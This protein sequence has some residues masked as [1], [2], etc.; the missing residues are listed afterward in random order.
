MKTNRLTIV[1]YIIS[2]LFVV[3]LHAQVS[4]HA[5]PWKERSIHN[6]A[7]PGSRHNPSLPLTVPITLP[8]TIP[9]GLDGMY[10]NQS[11]NRGLHNI[12]IDPD[13]PQNLH[14]AVTF[15]LDIT[16]ADT[17]SGK[18]FLPQ[19]RVYYL[20][21]SDDGKTWSQPKPIAEVHTTSPEMILMKRGTDYVPMIAAVRNNADTSNP[22][23][24]AL[25]IEQGKP[26]DGNFSE[27][28]TDRKTF[29]DSLKNINFPSIALSGDGTKIF[30]TAGIDVNDHVTPQYVQFG[31][32]TLTEDR[33]GATWGGWKPGPNAG[34]K[35]NEDP[36]GF[37]FPW[38]TSVRVSPSGKIGVLWFNRDYGTPDLSTYLSESSDGGATWLAVPKTVVSP[39]STPNVEATTGKTYML[40]PFN[41]D[42]WYA[43]ETAEAAVSGFY[44]NRDSIKGFYIPQSGSLLFWKEGMTKPVL[45]ISKENDSDLGQSVLDGSWLTTWQNAAGGTEPQGAAN[46]MNPTVA[47]TSNPNVFWIY[48]A[49]WQDGDIEDMSS[50]GTIGNG[51][52]V[53][54]PYFSI[55][56]TMTL[57]GGAN[58]SEASKIHGN[59]VSNDVEQKYDYRQIETSPWNPGP[60]EIFSIHTLFNVDSSA[61]I[62]DYAGNPGYDEVTW[63][64]ET[65]Q[66]SGVGNRSVLRPLQVMNYPNPVTTRT[67]FPLLLSEAAPVVI[68]ITDLLGRKIYRSDLGILNTGKQ[69]IS[70]DAKNLQAG[71]YPY[72]IMI[73]GV[74]SSGIFTV[75]R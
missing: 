26:G 67:V 56:R 3:R 28:L 5:A 9:I 22:Y 7:L 4:S 45:L 53:S 68:V 20:F 73:G 42:L 70:F 8:G 11:L 27:I 52:F 71:S 54:Y 29:R 24:C 57:D 64:F 36:V 16:E 59:D 58:F 49:A 63:L 75:T 69:E 32:F 74:R 38:S 6:G 15:G 21:S 31:T 18:K 55:W 40:V 2:V 43:D 47:R 51:N 60:S 62:I 48:F 19:L 35:E 30:M 14:A 33:K 41:F 25:Y 39:I 37:A 34:T 44:Y 13:H 65:G 17:V 72:V 50:I 66:F 10:Q 61:G 46:I 1:L 23:V 12:L